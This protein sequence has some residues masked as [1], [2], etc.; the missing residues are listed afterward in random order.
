MYRLSFNRIIII[1]LL[2]LVMANNSCREDSDYIVNFTEAN[3]SLE[4][5]FKAI[6]TALNCNYPM[7]DYEEQ[8]GLNWDDVYDE[9][10]PHFKELDKEYNSQNPVPDSIMIELYDSLLA[11]LHDG[12]L[13]M[14]LKNIHTGKSTYHI[15]CPQLIRNKNN[16]KNSTSAE[17][18]LK[19]YN[20]EEELA[21]FIQ[22]DDY[23]FAQFKDDI[24]YFRL[25]Q[26]HLSETFEERYSDEKNGRI[27]KLWESWFNCIQNLQSTGSLKGLIIDLRDNPGG[28]AKDYQYVLGALHNG[29]YEIDGQ[30]YK[31]IG[32]YRE[33][34]GIG[35]F[36]F[37]QLYP[38][39]FP[40]YER[41]HVVVEAPIVILV[42]G[43]SSSMA[44]ITT[45]SAKQLK[46]GYVIGTETFGAYSPLSDGIFKEI[47]YMGSVGDL[48]GPFYIRIPVAVTLSLDKEF[49]DGAGVMPNEI[50]R[51]DYSEHR[52]SGKDNQLDRALEYIRTKN[53]EQ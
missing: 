26:F 18:T 5:Q 31:T 23:I 40:V 12:H 30:P 48:S 16:D 37:S 4:G 15:F 17:P 43:L 38:C 49:L 24:V 51:L 22:E 25:P 50:V 6:W 53:S 32:Y 20:D 46:N 36:E 39:C 2:S 45:F 41:E 28:N 11:P 10:L 1:L 47:Y 33:K 9:Y 8:Q 34:T 27:Y 52:K 13:Y 29:D 35:R 14:D 42:N 19:Y 7:W 3:A 44:E 21:E